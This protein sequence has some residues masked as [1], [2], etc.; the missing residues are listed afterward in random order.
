M[1]SWCFR[2]CVYSRSASVQPRRRWLYRL[3]NIMSPAWRCDEH[4]ALGYD[5]TNELA[6]DCHDSFTIVWYVPEGMVGYLA[7]LARCSRSM[8]S[9]PEELRYRDARCTLIDVATRLM[10]ALVAHVNYTA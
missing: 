10:D 7:W 3:A 4:E 5:W 6:F 8:A 2:R 9:L 1:R